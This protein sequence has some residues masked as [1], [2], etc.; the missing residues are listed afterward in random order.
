MISSAISLAKPLTIPPVDGSH[1]AMHNSRAAV[2][3]EE[4]VVGLRVGAWPRF[5]LW[6]RTDLSAALTLSQP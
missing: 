5:R 1:L 4:M 3:L 2:T 6:I